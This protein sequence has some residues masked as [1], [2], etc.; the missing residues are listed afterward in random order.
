MPRLRFYVAKDVAEAL[1]S[2]AKAKG[3]SLSGYLAEL[4]R[5]HLADDWPAGFFDEIVAGWRGRPLRRPKQG[6][7]EVRD[8][9]RSTNL[10]VR[11]R[12]RSL[13]PRR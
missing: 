12:R 9:L 8:P 4:V 11:G 6:R 2:R 5:D 7:L 1:K 3:K 13:A 10:T